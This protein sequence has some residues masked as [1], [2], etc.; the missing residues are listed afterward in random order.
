MIMKG[1]VVVALSNSG[2]TEIVHLLPVIKRLGL[3]LIAIT[4]NCS[5][6]LAQAADVVLD[7]S[8]TE[9]ACPMNLAPTASTTAA[10]A[11]GDALA[12]TVLQR[13]NFRPE[14]FAVLHPGGQLGH[15]FLR[16]DELVHRG[17]RVPLVAEDT[18]LPATLLEMTRKRLGI[19][20][21]V[22]AGGALVGVISDGDLRRALERHGDLRRLA[23]RDLMT[24]HPKS[25][26]AGVLAE[27][28]VATME[29]YSIT[30]L[31]RLEAGAGIPIGR[32]PLHDLLTAGGGYQLR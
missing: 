32:V 13:K 21:V 1:D 31:F 26:A 19:T 28:A 22:D 18:S 15:G 6:T 5:S 7:A 27:Q 24:T 11:L 20:G 10:L 23:A 29:R 4:G 12:V 3:P 2:E 14:D 30:S 16:V 8:V 25:I 17:E 9:E